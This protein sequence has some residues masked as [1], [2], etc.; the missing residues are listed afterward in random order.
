[1]KRLRAGMLSFK[2]KSSEK[3]RTS[4][5]LK[6]TSRADY[7][8]YKACLYL[9]CQDIGY[10]SEQSFSCTDTWTKHNKVEQ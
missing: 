9:T 1:M 7:F 4:E 2:K 8:F 5:A 3:V 6:E 10:G